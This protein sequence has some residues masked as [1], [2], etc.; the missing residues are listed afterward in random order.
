MNGRQGNQIWF[1][2]YDDEGK[3]QA[4]VRA[5]NPGAKAKETEREME[6]EATETSAERDQ[7]YRNAEMDEVSEPDHWAMLHYGH[8][9]WDKH[10]RMSAFSQANQVRLSRAID[11]LRHGRDRAEGS[12]NWEEAATYT[13]AM[14]EIESL[15]DLA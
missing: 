8:L 1:R 14:R 3:Q 5:A 4:D 7:R 10:D 2:R 11:S 13:Q 15:K 12:G 6:V 9:A